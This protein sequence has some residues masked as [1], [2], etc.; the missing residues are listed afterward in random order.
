[1]APTPE[2][3]EAPLLHH[4]PLVL[5]AL[6]RPLALLRLEMRSMPTRCLL[7]AVLALNKRLLWTASRTM[8]KS[9]LVT[10]SISTPAVG[11]PSSRRRTAF[12]PSPAAEMPRRQK[13]VLCL[14]RLRA[15][16]PNAFV[17][18]PIAPSTT[19]LVALILRV[20]LKS[21]EVTLKRKLIAILSRLIIQ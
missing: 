8:T 1:M 7:A 10:R 14:F 5:A 12:I 21:Q 11:S 19:K 6:A 2:G 3:A 13:I 17:F 15:M 18:R 16:C 9:A 20:G 4:R